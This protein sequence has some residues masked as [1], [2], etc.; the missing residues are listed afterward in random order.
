MRY[1]FLQRDWDADSAWI[2]KLLESVARD[3][4]PMSV[5]IFPEGTDLSKSNVAKSNS[6]AAKRGNMVRLNER[7][8]P[9]PQPQFIILSYLFN[10]R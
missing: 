10:R 7:V 5:F 4:M 3:K 8:T 6:F 1:L 2:V 9:P